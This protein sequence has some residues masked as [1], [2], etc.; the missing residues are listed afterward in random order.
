MITALGSSLLEWRLLPRRSA[1]GDPLLRASRRRRQPRIRSCVG[2]APGARPLSTQLKSCMGTTRGRTRCRRLSQC[3]NCGSDRGGIR[4]EC[5]V[6]ADALASARHPE[7]LARGGR[8]AATRA[9]TGPS[10][11]A[12]ELSAKRARRVLGV[13][14]VHVVVLGVLDDGERELARDLR[15]RPTTCRRSAGRAARRRD[16]PRRP[17][18]HGCGPRYSA[19][20]PRPSA[21]S[22]SLPRPGLTVSV[23]VPLPSGSP[24]PGTSAAP[25]SVVANGRPPSAAET[26]CTHPTSASGTSTSTISSLFT[27]HLLCAL[28]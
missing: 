19:R 20:R 22:R 1:A 25:L 16:R 2:R 14:H 12:R 17:G 27:R 4:P 7:L 24:G 8:P 18:R 3:A 26:A 28:P 23:A 5:P 10:P 13:V 11:S 9:A 6:H 21:C 15:R